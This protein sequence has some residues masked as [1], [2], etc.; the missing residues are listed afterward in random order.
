MWSY[1]GFCFGLWFQSRT[2]NFTL[3]LD[4]VPTVLSLPL[5][6]V[7]IRVSGAIK[8][9]PDRSST[10]VSRTRDLGGWRGSPEPRPNWGSRVKFRVRSV[11]PTRCHLDGGKNQERRRGVPT[12]VSTSGMEDRDE[13]NTSTVLG[14]KDLSPGS[15]VPSRTQD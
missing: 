11:G 4:L 5:K 3:G 7:G 10:D 12:L 14:S 1:L 15:E 8:V 2:S 6:D 9:P 13:V